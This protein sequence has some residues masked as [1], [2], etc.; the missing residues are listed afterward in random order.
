MYCET[1]QKLAKMLCGGIGLPKNVTKMINEEKVNAEM[2]RIK[3]LF[4]YVSKEY[5]SN[6]T[7]KSRLNI[8]ILK[9]F[10]K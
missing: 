8:V 3:N 5:F 9:P 10:C 7:A 2:D 1:S 4:G 6:T